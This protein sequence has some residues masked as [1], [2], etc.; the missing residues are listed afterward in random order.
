V[1]DLPDLSE[2]R[3]AGLLEQV[4]RHVDT[5]A[6]RLGHMDVP[7]LEPYARTA[8][9]REA[10]ALRDIVSAVRAAAARLEPDDGIA[11]CRVCGCTEDRAC[12][13]GCSWV[14]DPR[15]GDL[16]SACDGALVR[17][18]V[19]DLDTGE[20]AV[21]GIPAGDYAMVAADPCTYTV[22]PLADGEHRI[23]TRGRVDRKP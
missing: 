12:P 3:A 13:G 21:R 16:C 14:E 17:I 1:P 22:V 7:V 10:Q 18:T 8:V 19:E 5:V 2:H 23:T 15:M 4:L 9:R 20:R 6:S 11:R